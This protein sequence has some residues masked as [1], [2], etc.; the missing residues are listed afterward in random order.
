[1]I[2]DFY[3]GLSA[4]QVIST[5]RLINILARLR[6]TGTITVATVDCVSSLETLDVA[7]SGYDLKKISYDPSKIDYSA[8]EAVERLFDA[9][10]FTSNIL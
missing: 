1:M 2:N 3:S 5:Y 7:M 8:E 10:R 6:V 4:D 9:F